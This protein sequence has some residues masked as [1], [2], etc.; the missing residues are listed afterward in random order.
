MARNPAYRDSSMVQN[1]AAASRLIVTGSSYLSNLMS[2]GAENF[3]TRVKPT[4]KPLNFTPTTHDRVRKI[5]SFTASAADLSAK[6]VGSVGK[7][8]QNVGASL[9][10]RDDKKREKSGKMGEDYKPG[11]M[12][13]S[14]IAF[15]TLADGIAYSGKSILQ[16]GQAA[17]STV[18]RHRWGD[19]AGGIA[20]QLAGGVTNVGLVYIDVTGVSRRA[21]IKSVA[22]GMVVGRVKGGGEVVV[23]GGDGGVVPESDLQRATGGKGVTNDNLGGAQVGGPST[24][25]PT[26]VGYGNAVPS[27]YGGSTLGEPLG[28]QGLQGHDMGEKGGSRYHKY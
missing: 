4:D 9:S 23:G 12:N 27:S 2:S 22:K 14:M 7:I 6:T 11:F 18:V 17:T 20:N 28:S 8:A 13:K 25:S 15:S 16:S 1:A 3:Q 21:V 10:K 19:E 5:H 24:T 26:V